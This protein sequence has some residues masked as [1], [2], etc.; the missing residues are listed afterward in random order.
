MP[1]AYEN[2]ATAS[3]A[4]MVLTATAAS[5]TITQAASNYG[6]NF[7]V[8]SGACRYQL[9]LQ[10][11]DDDKTSDSNLVFPNVELT[12]L[13]HGGVTTLATEETFTNVTL[14]HLKEQFFDASVWE[15]QG[16]YLLD[17]EETPAVE[18]TGREGN[19]ISAEATMVVVYVG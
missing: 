10:P 17:L 13:L 1:T 16:S 12:V 9:Q 11:Q 18:V 15:G 7:K 5:K 3:K 19:V 14:W 8:P 4:I 2:I 6:T